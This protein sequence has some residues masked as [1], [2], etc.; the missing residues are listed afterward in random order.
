M[1]VHPLRLIYYVKQPPGLAQCLLSAPASAASLLC[2]SDIM[3]AIRGGKI[4]RKR[5]PAKGNNRHI[6]GAGAVFLGGK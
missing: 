1:E 3:R 2:F 4:K 5:Q 6:A